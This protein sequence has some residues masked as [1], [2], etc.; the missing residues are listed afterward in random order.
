MY[1]ELYKSPKI[2]I[3]DEATSA[4]DREIEEKINENI[5]KLKEELTIIFVTHHYNT[6]KRAD[7]ILVLEDGEIV[8]AGPAKQLLNNP[9]SAI[10]NLFQVKV[11]LH[12]IH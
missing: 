12:E 8:E 2:L 10:Q 9:A 4:L 3:L 6:I 7:L 5:F 11:L 1:V